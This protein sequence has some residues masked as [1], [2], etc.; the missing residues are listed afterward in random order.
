METTTECSDTGGNRPITTGTPARLAP[1]EQ[2]ENSA[3]SVSTVA[4]D[5]WPSELDG[6]PARRPR[7]RYLGMGRRPSPVVE[8]MD[9]T[10]EPPSHDLDSPPICDQG[11]PL[12]RG[13]L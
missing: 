3:M 8:Q 4:E 1:A 2:W 7:R 5:L 9:Y 12:T 13:D 6:T 10:D 11:P